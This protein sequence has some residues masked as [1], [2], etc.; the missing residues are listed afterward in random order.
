MALEHKKL[1]ATIFVEYVLP[2]LNRYGDDPLVECPCC[3]ELLQKYGAQGYLHMA[4]GDV[5]CYGALGL[6]KGNHGA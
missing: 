1:M 3:G 6:G 4:D 2:V 5:D